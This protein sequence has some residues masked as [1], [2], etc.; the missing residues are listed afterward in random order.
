MFLFWSINVYTFDLSDQD[1]QHCIKR[2]SC[3]TL[4][5]TRKPHFSDVAKMFHSIQSQAFVWL[6]CPDH[7]NIVLSGTPLLLKTIVYV[8]AMN[9]WRSLEMV[10]S[11]K[12]VEDEFFSWK[13]ISSVKIASWR[14]VKNSR[15]LP[16]LHKK[17][18]SRQY[19]NF[20]K[21]CVIKHVLYFLCWI[22][23]ANIQLFL[24]EN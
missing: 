3:W 16:F 20:D 12:L 6:V 22:D 4:T 24:W 23:K 9:H 8:F 2:F 7:P 15:I 21:A 1:K 18:I 13:C 10:N 17:N 19:I 11:C 14:I 5:Y